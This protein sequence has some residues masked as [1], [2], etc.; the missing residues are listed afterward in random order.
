MNFTFRLLEE[1]QLREKEKYQKIQN[2]LEKLR[3]DAERRHREKMESLERQIQH[4]LKLENEREQ[5]YLKQ[6]S[7]L[8]ANSRKI[9][10]EQEKQLEQIRAQIKKIGETFI[11][12]EAI[13]LNTLQSCPNEMSEILNA[14]TKQHKELR[15]LKEH[16]KNSLDGSKTALKKLDALVQSLTKAKNDF[17]A[18]QKAR[19]EQFKKEEEEKAAKAAKEAASVVPTPIVIV[20]PHQAV[21]QVTDAEERFDSKQKFIAYKQLLASLKNETKLLEETPGLQQVRFALKLVINNAINLLNEKNKTTL[22]DGHKK[23]IN[24]LTGQRCPTSKGDV[25]VTDHIQAPTWCRLK[26][27]EKLIDRCEKDP[28]ITF[29]VAALIIAIWQQFPEFGEILKAVL[30]KECPFLIPFKPPMINNMSNEE[31]LQS[32]GF[33]INENGTCEDHTH[34]ESRTTKFAGLLAA[35]WITSPK[36]GT[37]QN[38]Y[39]VENGWKYLALVFNNPP[40]TN[41]LHILGKILEI[42]GSALHQAFGK[43][44]IKIMLFLKDKY[45]PAVQQSVDDETSAP[46]NRLRDSV[47]KFFGEGKFVEPKGNLMVGYW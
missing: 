37:G 23:L 22:I 25:A 35:L 44:F 34:Y 11:K 33:R 19:E 9:L 29:Y 6:R 17:E 27:A 3:Q 24:L 20:Q 26:I 2:D 18:A 7:E 40:D 28:N 41:Y 14:Y 39:G 45:I 43:Q 38:P 36:N 4:E 47:M 32:W 46:F 8:A 1:R 12:L 31:F 42:S 10:E 5:Q 30:Y 15:N 21:N 16:S 13:F